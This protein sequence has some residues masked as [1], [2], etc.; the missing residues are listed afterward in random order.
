MSNLILIIS[1]LIKNIMKASEKIKTFI[2]SKEGFSLNPYLCHSGIYTVGWGHTG[3]VIPTKHYTK[4]EC[5]ELFDNDVKERERQLSIHLEHLGISYQQHEFDAVFSFMWNVGIGTLI[6]DKFC[7][8]L[9]RYKEQGVV[10]Y[11]SYVNYHQAQ[12][13]AKK[14]E[15]MDISGVRF[16]FRLYIYAGSSVLAGLFVRRSQEALIFCGC[17][18]DIENEEECLFP[19][20]FQTLGIKGF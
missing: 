19:A 15:G 3:N 5:R 10:R 16:N 2:K 20:T 18:S 4:D 14:Y 11:A 17:W 13:S 9:E 8:Y 6:N 1:F 7:Y 12:F